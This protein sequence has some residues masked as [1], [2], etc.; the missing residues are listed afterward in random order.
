MSFLCSTFYE[1][2]TTKLSC[3][4]VV[5]HFN[6]HYLVIAATWIDTRTAL[7]TNEHSKG[8]FCSTR[9]CF[10]FSGVSCSF[11]LP[12]WIEKID[13][14]L[15]LFFII[16]RFFLSCFW[17][18][19]PMSLHV[20]SSSPSFTSISTLTFLSFSQTLLSYLIQKSIYF[21]NGTSAREWWTSLTVL[22]YLSCTVSW[23]NRLNLPVFCMLLML[24]TN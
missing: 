7:N 1:Q 22:V 17:L 16:F 12:Q 20:W 10:L 23:W 15:L 4:F 3:V 2:L 5:V 14:F 19:W 6:T 21:K 9:R 24:L 8:F 13:F 11:L 18:F